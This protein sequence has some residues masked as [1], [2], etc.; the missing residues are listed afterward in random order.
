MDQQV[1]F[2]L[3]VL[4]TSSKLHVEKFLKK[5]AG[6][7]DLEDAVKRLD[8]LTHEEAR[9]ALSEVLRITHSIRDEVKVV[10]GKVGGV[11]DKIQV[12]IDGARDMSSHSPI[13]V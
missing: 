11:D 7:T 5:L 13:P 6:R 1:S 12:V 3:S 9:M 8:N 2:P 10:D 4:P